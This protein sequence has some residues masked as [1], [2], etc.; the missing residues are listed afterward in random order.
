M[1]SDFFTTVISSAPQILREAYFWINLFQLIFYAGLIL[2]FGGFITRALKDHFEGP[3]MVVGRLIFGFLAL[4]TGLGISWL[5]PRFSTA[6]VFLI[7][8]G[9]FLDILIGGAVASVI[10]YLALRL[11]SYHLYNIKQIEERI[12]ELE[13]LEEKARK[14]EKQEHEQHKE[15]IR[16]PIRVIGLALLAAFIVIGLLGFRGFPSPMEQM[17]LSQE[18]LDRMASSL[19]QLSEEDLESLGEMTGDSDKLAECMGAVDLLDPN[20]LAGAV[21]YDNPEAQ[22]MVEDYAGEPV[23]AIYQITS[24]DGFYIFSLTETKACLSTTRVV[25]MCRVTG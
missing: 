11:V 8:Q 13:E 18:D 14:I 21:P 15:G 24:D 10:L 25:C 23:Q 4:V 19:E 1:A 6:S 2:T 20:V 3:W 9:L 16:N 7:L 17:G 5:F 22:R 12:D